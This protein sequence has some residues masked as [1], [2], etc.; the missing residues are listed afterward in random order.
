M[1][2]FHITLFTHNEL[3][4]YLIDF[5]VFLM[6]VLLAYDR[7]V[8]ITPRPIGNEDDK[9]ETQTKLHGS[10]SRYPY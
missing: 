10:A 6:Y 4:K 5:Y 3:R 8:N 1:Y 7:R 2:N 9:K